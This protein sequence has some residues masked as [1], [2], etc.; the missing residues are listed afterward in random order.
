MKRRN[1]LTAVL[2]PVLLA[3]AVLVLG[4]LCLLYTSDAADD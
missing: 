1:I 2:L 3:A 4:T